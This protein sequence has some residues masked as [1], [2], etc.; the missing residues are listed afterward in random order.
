MPLSW[1]LDKI[2]PICRSA[3][4][5]GHVLHVIS[6]GDSKDPGSA[7]KG[8][9][10]APQF[11]RKPGETK[12]GFAAADSEWADPEIRPVL[13]AAM[14]TLRETGVTL[15]EVSLPDYPWSAL[16]GTVIGAEGASVFEELIA[17][18]KVN[19]LADPSQAEGLKANLAIPAN[20]YLKAMRVRSLIQKSFREL[21]ENVDLLV[22]PSRYGVAPKVGEPLDGQPDRATPSSPGMHSLIPAANLAGLPGISFPCGFASGLPVGLQLVGPPFRENT[23]LSIATE[24]QNRTDF[25]KRRPPLTAG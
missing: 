1:T 17:S 24:F 11:A 6:G 23:L 25:H 8:F 4:D 9:Y 2:G 13:D 19:D 3:E 12:V 22:A 10:F 20:Q 21:F 14:K 18:G 7:G 15:V 16:I 5:C